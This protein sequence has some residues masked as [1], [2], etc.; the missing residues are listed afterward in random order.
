MKLVEIWIYPLKGARGI[1]LAHSP[2]APSGL[3]YDRKFMLV[4]ADGTFVTQRSHPT[5]AKIVSRIDTTTQ[6][7]HLNA[8]GVGDASVNLTPTGPRR[9][10]RIWDDE[11]SAVAVQT[12]ANAVL[13]DYLN[14]NVALVFVPDDALR[15]MKAPWARP[16]DRVGFADAFP[17]LLASRASLADLNA[18]LD[19]SMPPAEMSRFRPNLVVEGGSAFDE[20]TF[21]AA[22][23]GSAT[24]RLTKRC[25]R[26]QVINVD[27]HSGHVGREPLRTLATYRRDANKV[28]FAR[29][30]IPVEE[31]VVTEGDHVHYTHV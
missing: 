11:V 7:L 13:S 28:Y 21:S 20:D 19:P 3:R 29:Y 24:L 22:R 17:V 6:T 14:T 26:C 8:P 10:V 5:L 9:S 25:P 12:D 27:Q 1:Q 31:S 2:V 4:S 30:A 23:I 15:A 18:R 16:D